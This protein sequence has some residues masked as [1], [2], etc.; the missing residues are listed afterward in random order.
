MQADRFTIKSQEA[1]QAATALAA[2]RNHTETQPEHLLLALLEQPES[3]VLPVLRKQA[4]LVTRSLTT[5]GL[6]IGMRMNHLFPPFNDAIE[7]RYVFT[8]Y[9]LSVPK[10]AVDGN[11]TGPQARAAMTPHVIGEAAITATY[12]LNSRL[13]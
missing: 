12:T 11:F 5:G 6:M 2:S 1:L 8:L 9:A 10:L 3:V 7:H 13:L 4:H